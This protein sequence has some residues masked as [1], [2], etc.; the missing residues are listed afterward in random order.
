VTALTIVDGGGNSAKNAG[1]GGPESRSVPTEDLSGPTPTAY[2]PI[3]LE[4]N[5]TIWAF[6]Q[7]NG[8]I[9]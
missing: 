4:S 5:R 8:E 7:F 1:S 3:E 9:R 2:R 6:K